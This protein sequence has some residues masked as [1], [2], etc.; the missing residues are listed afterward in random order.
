VSHYKSLAHVD[1][2]SLTVVVFVSEAGGTH[3]PDITVITPVFEKKG[4]KVQFYVASRGHHTGIP[5]DPSVD[6]AF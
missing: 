3:L 2:P 6:L 5:T 1:S 4:E